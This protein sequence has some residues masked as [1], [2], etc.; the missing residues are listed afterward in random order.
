MLTAAEDPDPNPTDSWLELLVVV[1]LALGLVV[2]PV[3]CW[4]VP[5]AAPTV[6][7]APV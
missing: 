5:N 6:E 4:K 1:K 2:W 3:K 7:A